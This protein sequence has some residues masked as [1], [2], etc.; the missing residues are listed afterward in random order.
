M[1]NLAMVPVLLWGLTTRYLCG[2]VTGSH[3]VAA[4]RG[5]LAQTD[6]RRSGG[7]LGT[8]WSKSTTC[9]RGLLFSRQRC[10]NVGNGSLVWEAKQGLSFCTEVK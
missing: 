5:R 1:T 9:A 3:F 6:P 10:A 4:R 8:W 7:P 2:V